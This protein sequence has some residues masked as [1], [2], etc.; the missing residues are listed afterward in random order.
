MTTTVDISTL[1]AKG[2]PEAVLHFTVPSITAALRTLDGV[3]PAP[4]NRHVRERLR[5]DNGGR[6]R[7]GMV[8]AEIDV[9][10]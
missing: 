7:I 10:A 8:S 2:E 5:R 4:A 6:V 9:C 3:T 1:N